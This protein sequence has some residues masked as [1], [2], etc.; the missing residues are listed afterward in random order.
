[1]SVEPGGSAS[2][3][4]LKGEIMN[5]KILFLL[6]VALVSV[7]PVLADVYMAS[8]DAPVFD[9]TLRQTLSEEGH[10]RFLKL[11]E[12]TQLQDYLEKTNITLLVPEP[13]WFENI[14]NEEYSSMILDR[15]AVREALHAHTLNGL[16]RE[17]DLSSEIRATTLSG[18]TVNA[19]VDEEVG[20]VV[21][22]LI[23]LRGDVIGQGF[24]I[25]VVDDFFIQRVPEGD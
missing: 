23:V 4:Y 15:E 3:F 1:M 12:D 6:T 14:S 17:S 18:E 11:L 25:H 13:E 7:R 22:G 20:L 9:R 21:N 10:D 16:F 24:I 19:E 2:L 5:W 8:E